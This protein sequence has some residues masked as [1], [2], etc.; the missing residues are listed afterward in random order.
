MSVFKNYYHIYLCK[1]Y[2]FPNNLQTLL[3][4][5]QECMYVQIFP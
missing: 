4:V 3:E 2:G 5:L 1:K